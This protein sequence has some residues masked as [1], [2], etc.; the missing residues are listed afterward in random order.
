MINHVNTLDVIKACAHSTSAET[1]RHLPPKVVASV[2]AANN[3]V[4]KAAIIENGGELRISSEAIFK[5]VGNPEHVV[6]TTEED[7]AIKLSL[8]SKEEAAD[9]SSDVLPL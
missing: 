6:A 4:L 9:P 8:A 2:M 1:A 7:G 3:R 5:T